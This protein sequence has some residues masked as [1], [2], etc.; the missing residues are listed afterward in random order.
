MSAQPVSHRL[1]LPPSLP[2]PRQPY[3]SS[4]PIDASKVHA[5]AAER[6]MEILAY[7]YIGVFFFFILVISIGVCCGWSSHRPRRATK[8]GDGDCNGADDC[9]DYLKIPD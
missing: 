1:Q 7:V 5:D 3:S 6:N 9:T 8:S 4:T 2:P